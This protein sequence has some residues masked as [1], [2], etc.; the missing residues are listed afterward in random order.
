M[1]LLVQSDDFGF[2]KGITDGICDALQNGIVTCTGLDVYKRQQL[3]A[4]VSLSR[5]NGWL[6]SRIQN[7]PTLRFFH[8]EADQLEKMQAPRCV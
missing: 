2:T 4:R 5:L 1:K 7:T 6:N 3:K 8:Q